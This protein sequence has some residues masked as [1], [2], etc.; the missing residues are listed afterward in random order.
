MSNNWHNPEIPHK[1]WKLVN[2]YDVREYG[3]SVEETNYETCM[4]CNNERI[5]Y[6]HIVTHERIKEEFIVG[7]VCAEKMT[8]DYITPKLLESE[9]KNKANKRINWINRNWKLTKSGNYMLNFENHFLLIFMDKITGK[10]KCKI[11]D[12]F[13]KKIFDTIIQ[14]KLAILKGIE[15]YKSKGEW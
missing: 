14:A 10:Y 7:C 6:A 11:D 12:Q 8:D 2:V 5:R 1:G 15:Y 4:M 13:G 3:Q 9:L